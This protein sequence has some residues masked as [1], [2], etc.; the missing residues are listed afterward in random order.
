MGLTIGLT[1]G[2]VIGGMVLI[3]GKVA[4]SLLG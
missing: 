1:I 3:V 2:L 4:V